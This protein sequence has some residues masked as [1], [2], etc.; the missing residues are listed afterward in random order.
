MNKLSDSGTTRTRA[1][2][3]FLCFILLCG[4]ASLW[5][6]GCAGGGS[7]S[8]GGNTGGVVDPKDAILETNPADDA[9]D[10]STDEDITITFT[11]AVDPNS[12]DVWLEPDVAF[13][14]SWFAGNTVLKVTPTDPLEANIEYT[15]FIGDLRFEDGSELDEEFSFRFSTGEQ[16]GNGD[17]LTALSLAEI[18]FW[19]YQIQGVD[20][21]GA[22]E[23][24][25]DSHYDMLVLEPTRTDAELLDFDTRGMVERLKA[26][27]ASDGVHRKLIIAYV[28]IGEAEDWRWYW[29]WSKESEEAQ[30]PEE[31]DLADDWP[32]YI[33][34][35]DPDGWVG[36]YP[37][38]YWEPEWKDII[39]YG[40][41]RVPAGARDYTSAID[42]LILDGFD[43]IYLDWVEGFENVHVIAAAQAGGLDPAQEMI[44]FIEEMR[45][46]ARQRDADFLIIQQNAAALIDGH[47]DLLNHLDAIAQEGVWYD[48]IAGDDWNDVAGYFFNGP[49]LTAEYIGFLGQYLAADVPVFNCEYALQGNATDAYERSYA[50]GYVPYVTRRSLGQLTDTPPPAY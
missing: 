40:E 19:G 9:A 33:I 42:E 48:G 45:D 20:A 30:I 15:V 32:D 23:S 11:A 21:E 47:P 3:G 24:L 44:D 36:N 50:E 6:G 25:A 16:A 43:G 27:M 13:N 17:E 7:G 28:D 41:N 46:Y 12:L 5:S 31:T 38:A 22:I 8:P 37:V 18:R 2:G 26:T 4:H 35:R 29:T 14:R 49:N 1:L 34:A 39:I 10:I